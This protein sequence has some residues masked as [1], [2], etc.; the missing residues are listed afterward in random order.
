MLVAAAQIAPVLLDRRATL[1][2]VIARVDEAAAAG[3]EL[4]C[5]PEI[6]VPG[7]PVW[8]ERT[9]GARF[10]DAAQK[11]IFARYLDQ[12]VDPA[13][14]D[15]DE[16]R[17]AARR[18][19]IAVVLGI[20]ERARDRGGHT[21][22]CTRAYIDAAGELGS[23]H[24][25]LMPTYEERLVWGTGDGAG[26]VTHPVG[27]FT[28]GALNCWENWMPLARAALHAQG[29]DLHV[30]LWP[31]CRRNT[32]GITPFIAFEG[33]SYVI[34]VSG[35]LRARDIPEDTP[36]R[37]AI[38]QGEDELLLD[39]GTAIAGPDGAWV[40]PPVG[41]EETLVIADLDPRRVLEERQNFDPSGHYAR[42]DV[43]ELRVDRTRQ[44]LAT[45]LDEPAAR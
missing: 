16:V 3:C 13:R 45:F 10:N 2:K 28:L 22:Y 19:R 17:A 1:A 11:R 32:E 25:K 35:L 37:A 12:A 23:L 42:P 26:L 21:I 8:L 41:A 6:L 38:L 43:L 9:G 27:P 5:F 36:L 7:Y 14:G 40:V 4:V 39:G 29:E 20:A 34:S 30:A 15:L 44:R 31:G 24:R 18:G 33:R